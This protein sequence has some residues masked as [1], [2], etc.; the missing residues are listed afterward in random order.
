MF[1]ET[2]PRE[3]A[4]RGEERPGSYVLGVIAGKVIAR[5]SGEVPFVLS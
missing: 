4:G 3:D 5:D 1:A 2:S